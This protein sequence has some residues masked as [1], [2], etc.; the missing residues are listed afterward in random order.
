[1]P[2]NLRFIKGVMDS[3]DLLSLN[4]NRETLYESKI[5][6]VVSKKLVRKTIKMLRNLVE[7]YESKKKKDN[8]IEDNTKEV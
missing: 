3:D 7:K 1:M 4:I 2:K 6:K 5:I 8:G